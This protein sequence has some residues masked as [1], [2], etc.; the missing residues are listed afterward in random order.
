MFD[1]NGMTQAQITQCAD[2]LKTMGH[3][4]SSMEETA[5]R[6]VAY[7]YGSLRED[8]RSLPGESWVAHHRRPP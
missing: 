1:F 4:F 7:I 5:N 2:Q 6:I 8:F 3:G